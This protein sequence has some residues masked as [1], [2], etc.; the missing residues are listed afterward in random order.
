MR[1]F[2]IPP[3]FLATWLF[4]PAVSRSLADT[5][6]SSTHNKIRGFIMQYIHA[7]EPE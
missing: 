1:A 3:M 4:S 2:T 5:H 6:Y 7:G